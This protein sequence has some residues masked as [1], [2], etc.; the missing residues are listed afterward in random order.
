MWV[1]RIFP[2]AYEQWE[3]RP[4]ERKRESVLDIIL[5]TNKH[6]EDGGFYELISTFIGK[7]QAECHGF[8]RTD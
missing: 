3:G 8:Q 5:R 1:M 6:N 7:I 2:N 4:E